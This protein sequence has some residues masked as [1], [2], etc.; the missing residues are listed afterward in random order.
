MG[1]GNN[2]GTAMPT[3]SPSGGRWGWGPARI[4][5][6]QLIDQPSALGRECDV[7][8]TAASATG[9]LAGKTLAPKNNFLARVRTGSP[10]HE[11]SL[12]TGRF[13]E[14]GIRLGAIAIPELHAA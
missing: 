8:T 3:P 5:G 1:R 10:G 4:T 14:E 9:P 7:T 2:P 11:P 12:L 6:S 13:P